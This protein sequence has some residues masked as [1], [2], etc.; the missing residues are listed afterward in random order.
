MRAESYIHKGSGYRHSYIHLD[1]SYD[2]FVHLRLSIKELKKS[3]EPES[4]ICLYLVPMLEAIALEAE[5]KI[6]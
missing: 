5:K 1:L 3:Y 4:G 6:V 2:D